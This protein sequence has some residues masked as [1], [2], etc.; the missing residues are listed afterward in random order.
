MGRS[1]SPNERDPPFPRRQWARQLTYWPCSPR[2]AGHPLALQRMDP[3]AMLTAMCELQHDEA[4]LAVLIEGLISDEIAGPLTDHAP[5]LIAPREP[6]S[7][8]FL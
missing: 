8:R 1:F 2:A 4:P 5:A 6:R 7:Y 3:A